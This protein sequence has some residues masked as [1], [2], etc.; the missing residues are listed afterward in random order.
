M[1]SFIMDNMKK[2]IIIVSVII[3]LIIV[4][5]V[6]MSVKNK[7]KFDPSKEHEDYENYIATRPYDIEPE[8]KENTI[9]TNEYYTVK[10]C[11]ERYYE[12]A[13]GIKDEYNR[14]VLFSILSEDF[15]SKY[16]VS[17]NN[18]EKVYEK[19]GYTNFIIEKL[20]LNKIE[21]DKYLYLA[22]GTEINS[23]NDNSQKYG[24]IVIL[25]GKNKTFSIAPYEFMKDLELDNA[26]FKTNVTEKI[27][28]D[29]IE[30]AKENVNCYLTA[31]IDE[32]TMV[33]SI[34]NEYKLVTK[35]NAEFA[36][37][38]L[39]SNY[40]L[41]R[42][43]N[44]EEGI[45]YIKNNV[46]DV[47]GYTLQKMTKNSKNSEYT[48]YL[49]IDNLENYFVIRKSN[50]TMNYTI[51]LDV[52]TTDFADFSK[53]YKSAKTNKRIMMNLEK[54]KQMINLKD[55]KSAYNVL[56]ETF[57]NSNFGN[58]ERFAQ[59]IKYKWPEYITFKYKNEENAGDVETIKVEIQSRDN[60]ILYSTLENIFII[61][62]IDE[63]SFAMSFN[64][65]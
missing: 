8:A 56:D 33:K 32:K 38:L 16:D 63:N 49:C 36:Y 29:R 55:Y 9:S 60:A 47:F 13:T 54:F 37:N 58:V 59:Y 44:E 12:K 11:I 19:Y 65:E 42:F 24:F 57:R 61:K 14:N 6:V 5:I 4:L 25:D 27:S 2:I 22:Y 20:I 10:G 46:N 28:F 48:D 52:Y 53:A 21:D 35:Y 64:V 23:I 7:N 26:D 34:F 15:K 62:L 40:K 41:K 50:Q 39:D 30:K 31:D 1:K 43:E 18:I 45:E 17:V 51:L 3:V